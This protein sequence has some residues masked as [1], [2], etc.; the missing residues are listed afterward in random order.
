[1]AD[2]LP[3]EGLSAQ[4]PV[5]CL[6]P[7]LRHFLVDVCEWRLIPKLMCAVW[8]LRRDPRRG[9]LLDVYRQCILRERLDQVDIDPCLCGIATVLLSRPRGDHDDGQMRGGVVTAHVRCQF[10][11]VHTRHLQVDEQEGRGPCA[12]CW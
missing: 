1:M 8:A 3:M 9:E 10:Q 11:T 4:A 5:L 7:G 2:L 6:E 12:R